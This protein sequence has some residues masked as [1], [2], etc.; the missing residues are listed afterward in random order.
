MLLL[1]GHWSVFNLIG[2]GFY[3]SSP[4]LIAQTIT[5]LLSFMDQD[6]HSLSWT[7][8]ACGWSSS[9][10]ILASKIEKFQPPQ[11]SAR[12]K[13]TSLWASLPSSF[14]FVLFHFIQMV[15]VQHN[16]GWCGLAWATLV[17]ATTMVLIGMS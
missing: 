10:T 1:M 17:E 15:F 7:M 4:T 2:I 11:S 16:K 6:T 13:A 8:C 14:S 12:N 3:I 5:S 9:S